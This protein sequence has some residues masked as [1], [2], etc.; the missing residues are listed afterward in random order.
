MADVREILASNEAYAQKLPENEG[1]CGA[2]ARSAL[3]QVSVTCLNFPLH[4]AFCERAP[5]LS[6]VSWET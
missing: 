2:I 6:L 5:M 4:G 3:P 1:F